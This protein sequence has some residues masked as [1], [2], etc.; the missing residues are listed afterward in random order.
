MA[1]AVAE[2]DVVL[3]TASVPGKKAPL[4]ITAGMV[5]G[6]RPGSVIVDV[7]AEHGGNCELTK[8]GEEVVEHGVQ[9]LGPDNLPSLIP[10][11]ASQMYAR[12]ISTFL[13]HL[14]KEGKL[15]LNPEDEI[16]SGTLLTRDGKVIH[17]RVLELLTKN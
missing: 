17:P 15:E 4:L 16:V 2:C 9:I 1:R 7:A 14:V 6:M 8:P 3:T 13:L 12:N 5:A 11:H 10:V